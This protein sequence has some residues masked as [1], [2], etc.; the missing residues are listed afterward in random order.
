MEI[1]QKIIRDPVASLR[2]A[3]ARRPVF[4]TAF[5]GEEPP[6]RAELFSR[7]QMARH[8]QVLAASHHLSPSRGSDR[9]LA[10]LAQNETLLAAVRA[11]LTEA[12]NGDRRVT[13]AGEW[14]LDNF[15]LIE[16]QIRTARR[17]LPARYSRELPRLADGPSAGVPRVYDIA[18]ETIAHGDGHLDTDGLGDFVSAYQAVTPLT[19]GELWAIPIM[20]R[21]ALIENL[22][23]VAARIGADRV[24]RNHAD[25]WADQ[26]TAIA[27]KDPKSLILSIADMAR[28]EPPM[29]G[30]FVAEFARRLQGKS[31]ALALPLTWIE[32]RLSEDGLTIE[33]LVQSENQHQAA[34]Q[35][36]IK[37]SIGSLRFLGAADWRDFVEA[38]SGVERTLRDDPAGVYARMDF[39][40]RDQYRHVV[41]ATARR[42]SRTEGDVARLAIDLARERAATDGPDARTTHVGY[43]LVDKGLSQLERAAR[44]RFSAAE[45]VRRACLRHPLAL[46]LGSIVALTVLPTAFLLAGAR[47]EGMDGWLLGLLGILLLLC[48]SQVAVALVNTLVSRLAT[49][50]ALPKMDLS[51]G[52]LPAGQTLVVVPTLITSAQTVEHLVEAL[53]VRFLGNRDTHVVFG[54]LTDLADASQETLPEDEALVGLAEQRINDLNVKYGRS[55]FLFHRPRRW[56]PEERVWMGYE[57]KRGKLADLNALL[58]GRSNGSFSRVVGDT[59]ILQHVNV[60]HHARRRHAVAARRGP[61]AC[62][63]DDAPAQPGAVRRDQAARDGR[64]TASCS[65]AWPSASPARA[66]PDT[67]GCGRASPASIPIPASCR[68]S[69]R[70]C[71]AKARSSARGSTMSTRSTWQWEGASRRTGSSA[72]TCS[73]DA[74]RAQGC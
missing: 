60:R 63:R 14:L 18:L 26:M 50:R 40:T 66:G 3:I 7:E 21:L 64:A 57:R 19:I 33:Q 8:G 67:R 1:S 51:E 52:I 36:S 20:L 41:E 53:E 34:D 11:L 38:R 71:S 4:S 32:Q 72:T 42:S 6:L 15:Y 47:G 9:L 29:V 49:P 58:R 73:K 39:A 74:T 45:T 69:T 2:D 23:R 24:D 28:S 61:A 10:R 25:Y 70:T 65:R 56:N 30:S 5:A 43:F 17:H 62:R 55:F 46:Y 48:A 59:G 44:T 27:E 12:V 68:T 37:N 22:R 16:E 54:L 13:P 31:L 35:V